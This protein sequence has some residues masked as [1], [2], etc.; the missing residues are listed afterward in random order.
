MC[1]Y[2]ESLTVEIRR[3]RC[4]IASIRDMNSRTPTDL[5]RRQVMV[6]YCSSLPFSLVSTF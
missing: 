6:L 2:W 1:R 4:V 3:F 5:N